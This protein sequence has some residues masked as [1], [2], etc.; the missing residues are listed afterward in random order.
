VEINAVIRKAKPSDLDAIVDI[1]VESVSRNPLPVKIDREAM[2]DQA[3]Q[4][5][6]PTHFL[7]VSEVDGVVTGALAAF[8][9]PSF[10]HHKTTCSVLLHYSRDTGGW[11]RLMRAFATWVKSRSNIKIAVIELEP[12]H[13][14]KMQRFIKGLGFTRQSQNLTYVRGL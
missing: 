5:L 8:V 11:V 12:E 3:D 1:A 10:W 6:Q 14:E 2:R 7:M 4:C 13:G 9:S